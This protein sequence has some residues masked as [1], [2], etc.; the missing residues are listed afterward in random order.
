MHR[1]GRAI[2]FVV[3]GMSRPESHRLEELCRRAGFSTYNEYV[4]SSRFKTGA[5]MH[6]EG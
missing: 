3:R 2:D 6:I 1:Q 4:L 5:H